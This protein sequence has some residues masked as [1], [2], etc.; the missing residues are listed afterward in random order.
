MLWP[1]ERKGCVSLHPC[2][3]ICC[4]ISS[5]LFAPNHQVLLREGHAFDAQN[6]P[7]PCGSPE[8][9]EAIKSASTA[10]DVY[11]VVRADSWVVVPIHSIHRPGQTMEGTRLTLVKVG[12]REGDTLWE[13]VIRPCCLCT[14]PQTLNSR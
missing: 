11:H 12:E 10:E 7:I 6:R 5:L 2:L 9:V 4:P 13:W 3:R 8:Q 14:H 1:E